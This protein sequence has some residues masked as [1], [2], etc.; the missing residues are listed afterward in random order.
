MHRIIE[1]FNQKASFKDENEANVIRQRLERFVNNVLAEVEKRDERFQTSLIQSG[2]VYE[3]VKVHKPDEFDFMIRINSLSNK[4]FFLPCDKGDGYVKLVTEDDEWIDFKDDEGFFNP[5]K[6][7]RHFKKLINESLNFAE[8]PEGLNIMTTDDTLLEGAWGPVFS[9]V[10]G[11][12]H[13]GRND[14]QDS[15]LEDEAHTTRCHRS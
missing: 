15:G 10:L 8:V 14:Y 4:P 5:N 2:S 3:G 11:T 13:L 6:L 1:D 9:N 12:M 7:C